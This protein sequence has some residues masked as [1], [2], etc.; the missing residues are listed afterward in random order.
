MCRYVYD[1]SHTR[2]HSRSFS[3]SLVIVIEPDIKAHFCTAT[4]LLFHILQE[5]T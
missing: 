3:G 4:M 1:L 2:F 5:I